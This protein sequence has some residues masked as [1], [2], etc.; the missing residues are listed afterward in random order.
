[1]ATP[2]A[3]Q[4]RF[5]LKNLP[6]NLV[7]SQ[8][9]S[10]MSGTPAWN[11]QNRML[12]YCLHIFAQK[13]KE[14]NKGNIKLKKLVNNCFFRINRLEVGAGFQPIKVTGTVSE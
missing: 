3:S 6:R 9:H 13:Y 1:M 14:I 2:V 12:N 4:M 8:I 5:P 10:I 11:Q 7:G